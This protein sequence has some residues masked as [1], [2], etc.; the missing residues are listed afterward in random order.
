MDC[1]CAYPRENKQRVTGTEKLWKFQ[2]G[3]SVD[4]V[5]NLRDLQRNR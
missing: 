2:A 5:M 1:I 3:G 4:L